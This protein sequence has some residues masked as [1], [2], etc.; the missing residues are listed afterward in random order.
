MV[1]DAWDLVG[2]LSVDEVSF[3]VALAMSGCRRAD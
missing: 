3:N 2:C 1:A